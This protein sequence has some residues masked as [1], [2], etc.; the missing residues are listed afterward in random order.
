MLCGPTLN[1]CFCSFGVSPS[2]N[3]LQLTIGARWQALQPYTDA[4]KTWIKRHYKGE[5]HFLR[6]HGLSIY[7]DEDRDEGKEL[8]RSLMADDPRNANV[9]LG[10]N[11]RNEDNYGNDNTLNESDDNDSDDDDGDSDTNSFLN[12]IET[13]LTSHV[14]DYHFSVEQLDWIKSHYKHSGNFLR[15]YGLKPLDD[16]DCDEG[17]SILQAIMSDDS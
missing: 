3:C 16:Q 6:Q 5:Y 8:A 11:I 7:K 12:D 13:D 2:R 10:D 14:A 17:K 4:E 15:S 1:V 9:N